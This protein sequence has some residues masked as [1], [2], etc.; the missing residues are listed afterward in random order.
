[1]FSIKNKISY[2]FLSLLILFL[3]TLIKI[4]PISELGDLLWAEDGNIFIDDVLNLHYNSIIKSYAGYIHLYPR[5]WALGLMIFNLTAA[6]T[7]FLIGWLIAVIF[8]G[9]VFINS[10]L[11]FGFKFY[12]TLFLA[13]LIFLQPSTGEVYFT[14]T[15]AQW[16]LGF[17]LGLWLLLH[18]ESLNH[19]TNTIATTL[20]CLTGPFAIL[21]VPAL[22]V[23]FL[24]IKN[25]N[26]SKILVIIF[27]SCTLIQLAS[28]AA[29]DRHILP[30]DLNAS[31]W[32]N[33]FYI[34]VSFGMKSWHVLFAGIF[35]SFIIFIIIDAIQKKSFNERQKL[36][37]IIFI[38]GVSIYAAALYASKNS[39]NSITPTG[40]GSRYFWIPYATIFTSATL[41]CKNS[42]QKISIYACITSL[43]IL[44]F[45]SPTVGRQKTDFEAN[46][47]LNNIVKNDVKINPFWEVFPD[48]W[49]ISST[50]LNQ[51]SIDF[52]KSTV[53]L[54]DAIASNGLI[55]VKN[56]GYSIH[57]KNSDPSIIFKILNEC[58]KYNY[59]SV[60]I[61]A[62]R[63]SPTHTQ[64]FWTDKSPLE[65]SEINSRTRFSGS[66]R[67]TSTFAIKK[68]PDLKF[69]R[70]DPST[71]NTEQHIHKIEIYCY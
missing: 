55:E 36:S 14:I 15:N 40:G 64:L 3:L 41:L 17:A 26:P 30:T 28:F 46:L 11:H 13:S 52:I 63:K 21:L 67:T 22:I 35:W 37:I 24:L 12:E 39:P 56:E 70:I 18:N 48:R 68:S 71:D 19:P 1:M 38:F 25:W 69:I 8:T 29:S 49:K 60:F 23:K 45:Y 54:K 33:A 65:F 58:S 43:C 57:E 20:L 32:L 42:I 59:L 6:P 7:I 34:F 31:N 10:M 4:P 44:G 27:I 9:Y 66:N 16:F 2:L 53:T 5:L 61:D 62:T 50:H 47:Y 51:T